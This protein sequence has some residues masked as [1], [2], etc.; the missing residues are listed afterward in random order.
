MN[1]TMRRHHRRRLA[2]KRQSCGN[3]N[4]R[5]HFGKKT[6]QEQRLDPVELLLSLIKQ[7]QS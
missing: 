4:P 3:G 5:K 2:H 1:T 6:L 7:E